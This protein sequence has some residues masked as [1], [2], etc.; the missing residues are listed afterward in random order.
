MHFDFLSF[1]IGFGLAAVVGV[2]LYRMRDRIGALRSAAAGQAGATRQ[3]ITNS[4]EN[5]YFNDLLKQLNSYHIAGDVANLTNLYV[6]P[7]FLRATEPA[8]PNSEAAPGVLSVIPLV[9]DMPASYAQYNVETLTVEDLRAGDTHLALLGLPGSGK[10]T[11]LA[12]IGLVATGQIAI[13]EIDMM[14]DE[15]F[16]DELKDLP[17]EEKDK[18][19][20]QRL[21]TQQR[22]IE[23][24]QQAQSK[25]AEDTTRVVADFNRLMPILV[26]LRDI[27]LRPEA[28][29]VQAAEQG[30]PATIKTLDPAEPLVKAMQRRVSAITASTLPRMVYNRLAAG[31]CLLLV[32]GYDD[33]SVDDR[34][35]KLLWLQ[36]FMEIYAHNFIIITGPAVG[37]DALLNLGLT[38]IFLRAWSE[39]DNERL[40]QRWEVAWP[41]IA[42]TAHRAAPMPDERTIRR[43]LTNVRGRSPL[44]LTLKTWAAFAGDEQEIGRHAWYDFYVRHHFDAKL[45]VKD[46]KQ[47]RS[48]LEALA[49]EVLNQRRVPLSR[50]RLKELMTAALAGEDGKSTINVEDMLNKLINQSGLLVDWPGNTYGFANSLINAFLASET[51]VNADAATLSAVV[52]NPVW[53]EALPFAAAKLAMVDSVNQRLGSSTDL[54]YSS[55]FSLVPWL[56]DAPSNAAWRGEVFKR[57]TAALLAPSQFPTIRERA[58]AALVSSRDKNVLFILRQALRSTDADVRRLACIGLGGLGETDAIKDLGPMLTDPDAA[59]QL[60]AGMA[61]G[62]IGTEAALETML[63]GFVNGE[64]ALRQAVAESLAAVPGEG[65]AILRD[66]VSSEDMMVRRAA[67]FGL[68]RIKAAWALALLYRSLLEDEQWYVRNAAEEAFREAEGLEATG[69]MRHPEADSLTWLIAWAADKGEGVPTGDN[70]RQV[71]IRVLQEGDPA[72]RVAAARTLAGLGHVPALKPLYAALKDKDNTVRAAA[73]EALGSLQTRLGEKFPAIA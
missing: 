57:L 24:L 15:V 49:A 46:A 70:A 6:E 36:Q 3:F 43:V 63:G 55:L 40:V 44:D 62:A 32:D 29:G 65:H 59:V 54:L 23:H 37:Y 67:V 17:P 45:D 73:Y 21:E 31:T 58:M 28:F 1:L 5:R 12:I 2:V 38:P 11:A 68:A 7:H 34:P 14:S 48:A 8:D 47:G 66:A 39:L 10:S 51:L 60:A 13:D 41:A 72:A 56:G 61:L 52:A 22:A 16:E 33:L 50:D 27:D 26:H 53:E 69:A 9:H 42:H 64:Q 20:K 30:K 19:I 25:E 71:L 4:S 35:E 18:L